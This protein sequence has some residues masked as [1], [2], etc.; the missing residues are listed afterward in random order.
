MTEP[1][2]SIIIPTYNRAGE[3][4]QAIDNVFQQTYKNIELIVVDDGST[5]DTPARLREYG[6]RVRVVTQANAGPAVAR[7]RGIEIARGEVIA[8]QDSDDLWKPTKLERQLELLDRAGNNV[9]CCI[10]NA[11]FGIVKGTE[12]T[13]FKMA[14]IEPAH[15]EGLWMNVGEVLAT[16]FLL[17]NQVVAI[18]RR[19]IEKLG[20]FD[21]QLKYLEDYDL[22][23]RLSAEG[24]WAFIREPLVIYRM[25]AVNSF[26]Q[27]AA[28]DPVV[29]KECQIAIFERALKRAEINQDAR[30]ARRLA[31]RL[32]KLHR[33][34]LAAKLRNSSSEV[35]KATGVAMER[36][37]HLREAIFRRSLWYPRIVTAQLHQCSPNAASSEV[38][39]SLI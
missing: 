10:C 36:V 29:L 20:G 28:N 37:E 33:L 12:L 13:S 1:L 15:E 4:C 5:D 27:R 24:P 2:V 25:G 9:P 35:E 18:R 19:T 22:P 21:E 26:S 32:R 16:R 11:S 30:L 38:V 31:V 7:N 3:V 39:Q 6:S 34:L 8:F 17:F 23:L 14:P